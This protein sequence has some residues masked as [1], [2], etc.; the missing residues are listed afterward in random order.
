MGSVIV[1]SLIMFALM[2]YSQLTTIQHSKGATAATLAESYIDKID[3]NLFERYGDVQAFAMSEPARS[4]NAARITAFMN[5]MMGAYTPIY[6]VMMVVNASGK[7]I[8]VNGVDKS[9]KE[10]DL[11]ALAGHDFS[12]APWFKESIAGRVQPGTAFVE[13]PQIDSA[14]SK[15]LGQSLYH[16]NFTAPIRDKD[17]GAILGVWTNRMSWTDVVEAIT[18][19]ELKK[20]RTA[21]T[22]DIFAFLMDT[23]GNYIVHPDASKAFAGEFPRADK[24]FVAAKDTT[25]VAPLKIAEPYFSG[26]AYQALTPS[27]GYSIYPGKGW[28]AAVDV[29]AEEKAVDYAWGLIAAACILFLVLMGFGWLMIQNISASMNAIVSGLT[30]ES[31]SM[32]SAATQISSGAKNLAHDSTVQ[33]AAIQETASAVE[34]TNAMVKKS[35]DNALRSREVSGQSHE[36][37]SRGKDAVEEM[38]RAIGDI[39]VSNESI[40]S[41]IDESNGQISE[42]VKLITEIGNKTKVIN[43]IVFQTKLLSFNASVEAARA[44][45]HGKGFAVVAEEVGNLAQMSGNAAKEISDMLSGSIARVEGIVNNTK[46]QVGRLIADGKSKVQSGTIVAKQCGEI[47]E[48]VVRN[49]SEVNQMIGEISTAAQ[50]QSVGVAEI[51]KAINQLDEATHNNAATSH[52]SSKSAEQM[53]MQAEKLMSIVAA[54]DAL[55]VGDNRVMNNPRA[56]VKSL[57]QATKDYTSKAKTEWKGFKKTEP[58]SPAGNP[59]PGQRLNAFKGNRE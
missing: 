53:S 55:I 37:A 16:M 1:V 12:A 57:N 47:L 39:N 38:I 59:V 11:T 33:A 31:A 30:M 26:K 42:I 29:T 15:A 25:K 28:Y 54:L 48:D 7:V 4:G 14:V 45:E 34:E 20:V 6:D 36:A 49:V 2:A 3:R 51:T 52:E 21:E 58:K 23:K 9:G 43:D 10:L 8:A 35:A 41:Q 32:K 56:V 18:A 24:L 46:S 5:D 17:T 50:E 22:K 44:G 13:D 27:R 19:E 40:M